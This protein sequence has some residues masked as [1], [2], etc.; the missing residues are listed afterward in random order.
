M[1]APTAGVGLG[2]FGT[3][4]RCLELLIFIIKTAEQAHKLKA[5]C[6]RVKIVATTLKGAIDKNKAALE[7]HE[8]ASNLGKSLEEVLTFVVKCQGQNILGR[9]WE[10]RWRKRLPA[11]INEMMMWIAI[12]DAGVSVRHMTNC[13]LL[14]S[15]PA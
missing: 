8:A 4:I 9:A 14:C 12:V 2:G 11:L 15:Y 3:G 7:D 6:E 10:L 1:V 5:E 13:S